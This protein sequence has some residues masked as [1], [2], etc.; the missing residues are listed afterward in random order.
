MGD[1]DVVLSSKDRINGLLVS[2]YETQDFS[3]LL[4]TS[5]FSKYKSCGHFF[6]WSNKGNGDTR[7]S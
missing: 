7:I 6:S 2:S 3:H 4:I 5:E 1:F